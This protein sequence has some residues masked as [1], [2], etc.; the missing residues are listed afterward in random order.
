MDKSE[1]ETEDKNNHRIILNAIFLQFE[2]ESVFKFQI[3]NFRV[4]WDQ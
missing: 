1:T 2:T 3:K 4:F